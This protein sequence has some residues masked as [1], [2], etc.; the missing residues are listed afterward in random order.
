MSASTFAKEACDPDDDDDGCSFSYNGNYAD[1]SRCGGSDAC[2]PVSGSC[3]S[4]DNMDAC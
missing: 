4:G 1:D 2:F 3:Y